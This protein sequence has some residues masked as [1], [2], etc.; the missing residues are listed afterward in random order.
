VVMLP[1]GFQENGDAP[2]GGAAF[3]N[4]NGVVDG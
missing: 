3:L 4:G 1:I 2:Y